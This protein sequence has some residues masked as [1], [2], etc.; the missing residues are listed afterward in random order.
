MFPVKF[1]T[2]YPSQCCKGNFEVWHSK[3][4]IMFVSLSLVLVGG[5][6]QH[7]LGAGDTMWWVAATL[8]T[9]Y[10]FGCGSPMTL[11][12]VLTSSA[13]KSDWF[14][15]AH[16][17]LRWPSTRTSFHCQLSHH[18]AW[19]WHLCWPKQLDSFQNQESSSRGIACWVA[20]Q[21]LWQASRGLWQASSIRATRTLQALGVVACQTM[22]QPCRQQHR[23]AQPTSSKP[24]RLWWTNLWPSPTNIWVV[25]TML[26][27]CAISA[28]WSFISVVMV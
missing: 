28:L 5:K 12:K 23:C 9:F 8:A 16:K 22:L 20:A 6:T 1:L 14:I 11:F 15:F 19:K 25:T 26:L 21:I 24:H 4:N 13:F 18:S 7:P 3:S 10:S 17:Q 2:I 27:Q